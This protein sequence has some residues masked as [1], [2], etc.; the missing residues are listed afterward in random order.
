MGEQ[1]SLKA[2]M[3]LA[4]ILATCRKNVSNT[5][6]WAKLQYEYHLFWFIYSHYEHYSVVIMGTMASQI[7]SLTIVYST[8]C[9]GADQRKHQ[10]PALLAFVRGIHRSYKANAFTCKAA[11]QYWFG[12]MVWNYGIGHIGQMGP[13]FLRGSIPSTC[14]IAV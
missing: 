13:C 11:Y 9:S 8:I 2:A 12:P 3:P 14:A 5:G 7:T 4:E 10:S 1:L 6:P